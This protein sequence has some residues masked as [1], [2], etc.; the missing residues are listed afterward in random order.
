MIRR[1]PPNYGPNYAQGYG[2]GGYPPPPPPPNYGYGPGYGPR[3][4]IMVRRPRG[5]AGRCR[6]G[7]WAASPL[8]RPAARAH[9]PTIFPDGRAEANV[10]G[11]A[12]PAVVQGQ[13]LAVAGNLFDVTPT[14]NGIITRRWQSRQRD[15][16]CPPLRAP[17]H[18]DMIAL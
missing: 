17:D 12:M 15:P 6:R 10:N 8:Q 7:W 16:L 3:R 1:R 11:A 13:R 14:R 4:P 18:G 2:Y 9:Q 5:V